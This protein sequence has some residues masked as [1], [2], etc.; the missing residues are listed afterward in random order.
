MGLYSSELDGV[1]YVP[2]EMQMS[3][4]RRAVQWILTQCAARQK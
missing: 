2:G 4:K 1:K 3:T